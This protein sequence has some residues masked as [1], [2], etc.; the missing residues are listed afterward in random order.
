[1]RPN[2]KY[3]GDPSCGLPSA[4]SQ[5]K[6]FRQAYLTHIGDGLGDEDLMQ[7]TGPVAD[8]IDLD[9]FSPAGQVL[10]A[11]RNTRIDVP[12]IV[13]QQA[14]LRTFGVSR[15][16]VMEHD[17]VEDAVVM[18][19]RDAV[20][21][22]IGQKTQASTGPRTGTATVGIRVDPLG[23]EKGDD[24][25][26]GLGE[27]PGLDLLMRKAQKLFDEA[28][29]SD[30]HNFYRSLLNRLGASTGCTW[31]DVVRAID[32]NLGITPDSKE[33]TESAA[34][35]H[36]QP[37]R[38]LVRP[39]AAKIAENIRVKVLRLVDEPKARMP[40][41]KHALQAVRERVQ[42]IEPEAARVLASARDRRLAVLE[43][44]KLNTEAAST[45]IGT[46]TTEPLLHYY[47][48]ARDESVA[49][50]MNALLSAV[51]S[52]LSGVMEQLVQFGRELEQLSATLAKGKGENTL[53]PGD[54][55]LNV[56]QLVAEGWRKRRAELAG[57]VQQR[58]K[59]QYCDPGGGLH[60][61]LSKHGSA[62]L[63][64][65]LRETARLVALEAAQTVD[66]TGFLLAKA[67][68]PKNETVRLRSALDAATPGLLSDGGVKHLVA[69]LPGT[70]QT[71]HRADE[72]RHVIDPDST[73]LVAPGNEVTIC[74][75]C[76]GLS[77]AHL[78]VHL[79][80]GRR[81][82]FELAAR[83][84]TRHDINWSQLSGLA[85]V[86]AASDLA[87]AGDRLDGV[88]VPQ[89]ICTFENPESLHPELTANAL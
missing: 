65:R 6:P 87:G 58:L 3:P 76:A 39:A 45:P 55:A 8:Y 74:Y 43:T 62:A 73:L 83:V 15:T 53:P 10:D 59:A 25:V 22:W 81:D 86:I 32:S 21:G 60:E 50:L 2:G 5:K 44:S 27:L 72:I 77:L 17:M 42:S 70:P 18:L 24:C 38:V 30:P 29:G 26:R 49:S 79:I 82:Y 9:L 7:A 35:V 84:H 40:G 48:R 89:S 54:T 78:A 56:R 64:K 68:G 71:A 4:D 80:Q 1:M 66:L 57:I 34:S 63:C 19:C 23:V 20:L 46:R 31:G 85:P 67:D 41:A 47:Q 14:P 37:V 13:A 12:P 33:C 52:E 16:S 51:L 11:C 61:V 28:I 69:V 88:A 75:E 36:G